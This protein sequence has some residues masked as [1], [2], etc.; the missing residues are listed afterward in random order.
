MNSIN[1]QS[2]IVVFG[3]SFNPPGIHHREIVKALAKQFD[4]V[5]ILPCGFRPDKASHKNITDEQK[6]HMIEK[7]FVDLKKCEISFIDLEKG[8]YTRTYELDKQL[9]KVYG[10]NL[11]YA[12]GT[13]LIQGGSRGQSEIQSSWFRGPEL[14]QNLNFAV[15][16]RVDMPA[17]PAD[18]PPKNISVPFD[19]CGSSSEIRKRVTQSKSFSDLVLPEVEAYIIKNNLYKN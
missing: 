6:R 8:E 9:Q 14:W 19:H 11:W 13:D 12:V 15:I 4:L 17:S 2:K 10:D 5:I 7:T 3:G 18:L 16:T 1:Q